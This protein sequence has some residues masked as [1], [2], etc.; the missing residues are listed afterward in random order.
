MPYFA[1][2]VQETTTTAG[3][4]TVT[5][6][7]AKTGYQSFSNALVV[8]STTQYCITDGTSWEIGK[9]TLLTSTTLSRDQVLSSSNGNALVSFTGASKDVFITLSAEYIDN[10]SLG[11]NYAL[12]YN[13]LMP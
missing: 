3:T 5:L 13:L 11:M 10:G 7:G 1:D 9:G 2:R 6:A 4:G 12:K 8:G